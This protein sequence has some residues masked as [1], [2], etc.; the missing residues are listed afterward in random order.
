[1]PQLEHHV[2]LTAER[3]AEMLLEMGETWIPL[4]EEKHLESQ[5]AEYLTRGG[6]LLCSGC[7]FCR[8]CGRELEHKWCQNYECRLYLRDA[9][10]K[11]A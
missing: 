3:L 7:T 4:C 9:R 6:E 2:E 1:M 5:Y 8:E 10:A 11:D